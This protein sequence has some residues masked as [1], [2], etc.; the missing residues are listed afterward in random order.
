M[1][2]P[3]LRKSPALQPHELSDVTAHAVEELLRE[4][5]SRNT[6]ASYRAALRYW[7]AWFALRY[8][9]QI[10]LPVPP[11]AVL[12]FIVD[13][14][15]RTTNKG[16]AHELPA[17]IDATLVEAGF[18]GKRGSFSLNT[19]VHRIAVLSKAHQLRQLKNPCQDPKVTELLAMTRRAYAKRGA[20]PKKKD[21]LTRDPLEAILATCDESLRGKRDRALLLF[22]WATGGRRRSEVS[23]ANMAFLKPL[24]A[25]EFSY[26]LAHSK[27]NQEGADRPENYKPVVGKAALALQEWLKTA[28]ITEGAI[29]RRI[30]KGGHVGEPLSAAAVR[31]IVQKRCALA[32]VQGDFSAHSLRSG[33]VTEAARQQV[34]LADTMA[35]TGHR[36]VQT[37]L[38]YTRQ[39]A[40]A[41]SG[42]A[43]LLD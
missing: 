40:V 12:Q 42:A 8:G 23:G 35:M 20:L 1:R 25:G 17:A 43:R 18:K 4:G 32:G 41:K 26:L 6:V 34:P 3:V 39:S 21:A 16:L 38:G 37:V 31:D 14:A 36:S 5:E 7:A 13:H 28:S 22:A 11:A 9:V 10:T 15:Q 33:F 29:F 24:G 27:A 2:L 19:I 30:R